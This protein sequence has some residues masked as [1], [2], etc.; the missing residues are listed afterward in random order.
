MAVIAEKIL[1][2]Q[3]SGDG[4]PAASSLSPQKYQARL[5]QLHVTYD[6]AFQLGL[7]FNTSTLTD[8]Y[9]LIPEKFLMQEF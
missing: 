6:S 3:K 4:T 1:G 7:Q 5:A 9:H 8:Y 2:E